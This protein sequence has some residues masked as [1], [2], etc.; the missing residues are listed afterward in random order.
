MAVT[1]QVFGNPFISDFMRAKQ[2][3]PFIFV[4]FGATG[5]L[6]HRKLLPALFNLHLDGFL[7]RPHAIVGVS[8]RDRSNGDYRNEM[9]EAIREHSRRKPDSDE[10]LERFLST[11]SYV[12][13]AF[14]DADAYARL[15]NHIR[16]TSANLG[17]PE[18]VLY[19]LATPPES[20][21]IIT[22][23]LHEANM[24]SPHDEQEPWARII[25][26]KP[27][28]H[29]AASAHEL[30]NTLH[31]AFTEKQVYR[32]DHYLGKET[33]QNI[34]I[35]RLGNAIFEPL[36]N[37]RYIDQVQISVT[38]SIGIGGRAGY[39]DKAGMIRDMVQSHIMQ[40]LT[41]IAM[42]PPAAFDAT[43]IRDEKVKALKSVRELSSD[44]LTQFVVRGQYEPGS[45]G[46]KPV[47]GYLEEQDVPSDS[48]TD[49]FVALKLFIDNWRWSGVPFYIRTGK[50]LPKR[51]TEVDIIFKDPPHILFERTDLSER[52]TNVIR[53]RIQPQEGISLSFHAKMPGQ[54]VKIAPVRMDFMY[55]S[56][57]E[58]ATAEAY[59]RLLLDALTGDSTLF[60]REDEV[61]ISWQTIDRI[62][63]QWQGI[64]LHMYP[65]GEWGPR[66]ADQLLEQDGREWLRL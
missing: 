4:I 39:F 48:R 61:E 30:N 22:R 13:G 62:V 56:A 34:L 54:T 32:I 52:Q 23:R 40:V 42:E 58:E 50:R 20:F 36:W 8:R 41:M 7:S 12:T 18:N 26:E 31:E 43:S 64:P 65:A 11:V 21:P 60:A 9:A 51:V 25:V 29:D 35:F 57:F 44:D 33:V 49:T 15:H 28:G 47:P 19:Y 38:E 16:D 17:I 63:G 59:E 46:G 45:I 66:A 10:Q 5:D 1:T 2:S 27:F 6:S 53:F 24:I 55:A 37:R 3:G 14:G